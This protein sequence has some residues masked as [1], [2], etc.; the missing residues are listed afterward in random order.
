MIAPVAFRLG[1]PAA[2][3]FVVD[4]DPSIRV[5]HVS[6]EVGVDSPVGGQASDRRSPEVP[7][8]LHCGIASA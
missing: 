7:C 8:G 4:S 5:G 3:Q 2:R 6:D 1:G